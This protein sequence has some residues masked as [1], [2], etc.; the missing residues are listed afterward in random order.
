MKTSKLAAGAMALIVPATVCLTGCSFG[1]FNTMNYRYDNADK[2]EAGNREIDD[3]ITRINLDYASGNVTVKG[4]DADSVSVKERV[5]K[6]IDED[7][8]VHTWV[9]GNTLYIRY[10][11]SKDMI[12]FSGIEKSLEVTIPEAQNLNDFVINV[13]SGDVVLDNFTTDSLNSHASSGNTRIDCSARVIEHKSS[14]G[15]VELAQKGNADSVK[16][17]LSSGNLVLDQEGDLDSLDIDSSSGKIEVHQ[18]G[19]VN[20]ARIHSSSGGAKAYMGTVNELTIE[21][22]SGPI[23]LSADEVK[24][25]NT[26]ASS[27]HSDIKLDKAPATSRIECSSGGIDVSIPEDSDIT[28]HVKISSGEFDYELPFVKDGKDYINGNGT[29]DME[30]HCSSGD[31]GFHKI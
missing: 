20:K 13:S 12:I 4:T 25:L 17:K 31:V 24:T 19:T 7:H 10:C 30:I 1:V 26:K 27:G 5:N 9:D 21:V 16:V 23:V 6:D 8:Q 11:V 28:V 14:S 2:Y 18:K 22:S 3:K 29:N 15:N